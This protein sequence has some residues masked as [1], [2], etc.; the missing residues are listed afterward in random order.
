[1][2]SEL[3]FDIETTGIDDFLTLD[4]LTAIHCIGVS[5]PEGKQQ[6]LYGPGEIERGLE[7][8]ASADVLIGHNI[9]GFDI[10]AITKLYPD[11][12][13]GELYDTLVLSRL[14]HPDLSNDDW[15]KGE[16]GIPKNLRGLHS[17]EA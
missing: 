5:D 3:I 12:E 16:S 1:L 4:G 14:V 6:V 10:P 8:L 13:H 17:L 2:S 15:A 11:W 7:V 9:L